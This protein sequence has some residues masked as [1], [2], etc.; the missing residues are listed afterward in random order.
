MWAAYL[1]TKAVTGTIMLVLGALYLALRVF[2]PTIDVELLVD[3]E[4]ERVWEAW[5]CVGKVGVRIPRFVGVP[6]ERWLNS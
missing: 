5:F 2:K 4:P 6:L 3:G 1:A